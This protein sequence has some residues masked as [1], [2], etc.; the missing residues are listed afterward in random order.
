MIFFPFSYE[1]KGDRAEAFPDV[2]LSTFDPI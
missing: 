1:V 2:F